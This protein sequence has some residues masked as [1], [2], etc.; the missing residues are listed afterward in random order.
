MLTKW[1]PPHLYPNQI[2]SFLP[3]FPF[4]RFLLHFLSL[5]FSQIRSPSNPTSLPPPDSISDLNF[6]SLPLPFDS[7]PSQTPPPVNIRD[8]FQNWLGSSTIL[9]GCLSFTEEIKSC[10]ISLLSS[11]R[12]RGS[13]CLSLPQ[14]RLLEAVT[15][16][17]LPLL[18]LAGPLKNLMRPSSLISFLWVS[19]SSEFPFFVTYLGLWLAFFMWHF[20][21]LV[22]F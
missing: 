17:T 21:F 1:F 14:S 19:G 5:F 13:S 9:L 8:Q 18:I 7:S 22:D 6:I 16:T 12:L 2:P 10:R 15:T 11:T 3:H 20:Y 4:P